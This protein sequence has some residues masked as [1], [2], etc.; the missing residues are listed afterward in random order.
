MKPESI[1]LAVAGMCF[2]VI[3]GWLLATIDADRAAARARTTTPVA[4]T[5]TAGNERQPPTLDKARVQSLTTILQSDP[6]NAEAA[7][8]L[9]T[10]YF[11]A[12]QFDE[13]L[14]WYEEALRLDPE[15]Q[16]AISQLGMTLFVTRGAD[17]AL[18]QFERSLT[19]GPDHPGTLLNKGIVLWRGKNDLEGA[20]ETWQ[21][22]VKAAPDTPEAELARQGL[23]AIGAGHEGAA[24][25]PGSGP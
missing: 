15:N 13:A 12:Q 20:G 17:P 11:E 16:D 6:K 23:Q 1:V 14:K 25:T 2:G 22:L 9:G 3:V 19:L 4:Q 5:A 24:E 18:E 8:Q 7:E 10:T 21:R